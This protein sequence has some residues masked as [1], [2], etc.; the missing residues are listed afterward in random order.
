[1]YSPLVS[2]QDLCVGVVMVGK[3]GIEVGEP[4]SEVGLLSTGQE[5]EVACLVVNEQ[6]E[7]MVFSKGWGIGPQISECSHPKCSVAVSCPVWKGLYVIFPLMQ[8]VQLN[9][10]AS[11]V[12]SSRP[13]MMP[14]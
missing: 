10:L 5:P 11:S 14:F 6:T 12:T 8:A 13:S 9:S 2:T 3:E 7:I 4:G 1:M